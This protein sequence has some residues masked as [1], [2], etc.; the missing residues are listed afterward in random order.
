[1]ATCIVVCGPPCA[2][3]STLAAAVAAHTGWPLLAKD[4]YKELI[5]AHLGW[6]DREWSRRVSALAWD[7]LLAEAARLLA[8]GAGC[9]LEGNFRGAQRQA[10]TALP[11]DPL[12]CFVE[13][14]C[15]ARPD[16]LLARYRARAGSGGRHP[17]HVD[18]EALAEVEPELRA[19][20]ESDPALGGPL[21]VWDTSAGV[22]AGALLAALDDALAGLSAP[23][24]DT[25]G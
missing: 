21:L 3:K 12:P 6:R 7:L 24:S 22:A 14:R 20:A 13:V 25:R 5:F 4:G 19:G 16:V 2:G 8:A 11:L 23:A 17:G 15:G 10:L 9:V 1:M 18:L